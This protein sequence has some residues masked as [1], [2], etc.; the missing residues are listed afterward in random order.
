MFGARKDAKRMRS[1]TAPVCSIL[2]P[3]GLPPRIL[4]LRWNGTTAARSHLGPT[5]AGV[6][7]QDQAPIWSGRNA[8]LG[9]RPSRGGRAGHVAGGRPRTPA[10]AG[11]PG[12]PPP[13]PTPPR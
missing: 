1:R 10:S 8:L 11:P 6:D 9:N 5:L 7:V 13:P 4:F 3:R 12:S 2:L